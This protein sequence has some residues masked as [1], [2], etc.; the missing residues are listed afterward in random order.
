[1]EKFNDEEGCSNSELEC[2]Y[3]TENS[4]VLEKRVNFKLKRNYMKIQN[5]AIAAIRYEVSNTV[6]AIAYGFL[7]DLLEAK[8][9]LESAIYLNFLRADIFNEC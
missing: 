7:K 1:M 6:A 9:V 8:I 2:S 5:T 3:Y 4:H